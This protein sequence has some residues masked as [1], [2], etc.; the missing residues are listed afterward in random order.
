[1][2]KLF[3]LTAL[4]CT[5][6]LT[7]EAFGGEQLKLSLTV[8]DVQPELQANYTAINAVKGASID[9]VIITATKGS[10]LTWGMTPSLIAGLASHV[11][12]SSYVISGVPANGTKGVHTYRIT[13]A[14]SKGTVSQ[15][16]TIN[17]S[18]QNVS[19]DLIASDGTYSGTPGAAVTGTDSEG[20][21]V[22]ETSTVF[23][24]SAGEL[25]LSADIAITTASSDFAVMSGDLF[26]QTVSVDVTLAVFDD[27]Y[28]EYFYSMDLS[29]LPEWLTISGDIASSHDIQEDYYHHEFTISGYPSSSDTITL[30]A[31][32]KISGDRPIL[33]ASCSKDV[34]VAVN[35]PAPAPTPAPE[36]PDRTLRAAIL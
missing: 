1:M 8:E 22:T 33:A 6:P 23:T 11:D 12:G 16:I 32:V 25:I 27:D 3:V 19:D 5:L 15:D 26:S 35:T 14:N 13:A 9:A 4:V 7:C 28:N 24:N 20:R 18:G 31:C 34:T 30:T 36:T 10:N 2:K 21:S 17:V 29:G